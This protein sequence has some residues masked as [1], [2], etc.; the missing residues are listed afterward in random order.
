MGLFQTLMWTKHLNLTNVIFEFDYKVVVDGVKN[1]IR[2]SLD[3][4]CII[5]KCR[6]LLSSILNSVV[7]FNRRIISG[8][9]I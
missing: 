7:S 4:H 8:K 5:Y 2:D 6:V 9:W 1:V 3:F